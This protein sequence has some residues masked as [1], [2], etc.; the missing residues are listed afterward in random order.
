MKANLKQKQTIPAVCVECGRLKAENEKLNQVLAQRAAGLKQADAAVSGYRRKFEEVQ[1]VLLKFRR[2][3]ESAAI[4]H[5]EFAVWLEIGRREGFLSD[6]ELRQSHLLGAGFL[7]GRKT[8]LEPVK[9][10]KK[11]EQLV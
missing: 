2:R 10:E 1:E 9:D 6:V 7:Y 11:A 5:H 8:L 4:T 3:I